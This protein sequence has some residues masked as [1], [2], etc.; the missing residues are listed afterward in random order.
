[1]N[2]MRV[3][4]AGI[5]LALCSFALWMS[6]GCDRWRILEDLEP[7]ANTRVEFHWN[8]A[9]HPEM[10]DPEGM[11]I[12]L[13]PSDHTDYWRFE[14]TPQGGYVDVPD[15]DY[16]IVA[17]NN[18]TRS[19]IF[20]GLDNFQ[21]LYAYTYPGSMLEAVAE[22]FRGAEPPRTVSEPV[23][24]EPDPIYAADTTENIG[25]SHMEQIIHMKPRLFTPNYTVIAE[26]IK[27]IGSVSACSFSLSGLAAGKYLT[28]LRPMD[29]PV[30]M[31]GSMAVDGNRL[32]GSLFN[33]GPASADA[34]HI[35]SIYIW[36]NNKE[37]KVYN[38][39]VSDQ[40]NKNAG[41]M[42]LTI[43]VS[44]IE[45]P[46]NTPGGDMGSGMDV[47]VDNWQVENIELTN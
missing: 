30:S 41:R 7:C 39:D 9:G 8:E 6:T 14:L 43:R 36:L 35:L 12:L 42:F 24:Q 10:T 23:R 21:G 32:S 46:E 18:D 11:T 37:K 26:E 40:I 4:E 25:L 2:Y 34:K 31:P 13:Y 22:K 19:V 17:M 33:F 27:N 5:L 15:G 1:M 3:R 16:S 29:S 28:T 44:G 47:D 38:F 45:L 20:G